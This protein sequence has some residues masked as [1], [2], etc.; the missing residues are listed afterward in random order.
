[1]PTRTAAVV[2]EQP[3]WSDEVK[4]QLIDALGR[5]M[6][7]ALEDLWANADRDTLQPRTIATLELL[8]DLERQAR[9]AG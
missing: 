1:M 4:G 9:S 7:E 5:R 6:L 3:P 2:N 8:E